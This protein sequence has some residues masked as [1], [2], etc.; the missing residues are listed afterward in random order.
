M[1]LFKHL[2][3]IDS[4]DLDSFVE[5]LLLYIQL[6]LELN[7]NDNAA[8]INT[9][10]ELGGYAILGIV[11]TYAI[12]VMPVLVVVIY[13][14]IRFYKDSIRFMQRR[15]RRQNVDDAFERLSKMSNADRKKKE[16]E[17]K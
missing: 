8:E 6:Y 11:F 10:H 3:E 16:E 7:S 2:L 17:N 13:K 15:K 5:R 14:G 1:G 4:S 9:T 12:K